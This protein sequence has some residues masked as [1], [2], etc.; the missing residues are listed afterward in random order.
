MGKITHICQDT[1]EQKGKHKNIEMFMQQKGITIIR[2]SGGL[3][4]GDYTLPLDRKVVIDIKQDVI[5][6]AGN[7]CGPQHER[8][9]N[10][11]LRA[12]QVGSQLYVLIQENECN[13]KE[14]TI[15]EELVYWESPKYKFDYYKTEYLDPMTL[16]PVPKATRNLEEN[17]YK[18]YIKSRKLAHKKGEPITN[19]KGETLGK[20]M[21]TMETKYGVKFLFCKEDEAGQILLQLLGDDENA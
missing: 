19:V 11:C 6:I 20:V 18:K 7:L 10:E 12:Q 16:S 2:E 21:R 15:P 5:E 8:F 13:G 9:R 3:G 1:R 14:I 4:F 17:K